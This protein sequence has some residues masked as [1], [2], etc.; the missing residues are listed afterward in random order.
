M[1]AVRHPDVC[2]PEARRVQLASRNARA[3]IRRS[4][5]DSKCITGASRAQHLAVFRGISGGGKTAWLSQI[6]SSENDGYKNPAYG[7][8]K[9]SPA[10]A[11]LS[12]FGVTNACI[13][14]ASRFLYRVPRSARY[15]RWLL[16]QSV[17]LSQIPVQCLPM[18]ASSQ[19]HLFI[20]EACVQPWRVGGIMSSALTD[21]SR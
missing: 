10:N 4:L 11:G 2:T 12:H 8:L 7:L 16:G 9:E 5:P 14:R 19:R 13:T 18:A 1:D 20:E 15:G 17:W 6:A 21:V 3:T